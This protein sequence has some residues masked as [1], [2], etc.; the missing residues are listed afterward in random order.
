M[1]GC[2]G[3]LLRGLAVPLWC[4]LPPPPQVGR[5]TGASKAGL[6][7]ARARPLKGFLS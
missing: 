5:E 7:V 4:F 2:L 6:G 3:G 1:V